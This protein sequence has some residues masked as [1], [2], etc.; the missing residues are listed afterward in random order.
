[1]KKKI[2]IGIPRTFYYS[3]KGII[4]KNFFNK[5]GCNVILSPETNNKIIEEGEK[6]SEK[7]MCKSY[8]IY[9]GHIKELSKKC[10][11]II[12]MINKNYKNTCPNFTMTY[13]NVKEIIP[14]D[15]IIPYKISTNKFNIEILE[16]IKMGTYITPNL[17][18]I[19]KSYLCSVKKQRKYN[20]NKINYQKH[21]QKKDTQKVL[22]MAPFYIMEEKLYLNNIINKLKENNMIPILSNYLNLD[23]SLF[24]KEYFP[25]NIK[26]KYINEMLGA[27][28]YY[29]NEISGVINILNPNCQISSL[30]NSYFNMKVSTTP[31]ISIYTNKINESNDKIQSFILNVKGKKYE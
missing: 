6:I 18:K 2:K 14:P 8:Q 30:I 21:L 13:D 27:Y 22:I 24:F 7:N 12:I 19:I 20:I 16:Y 23:T 9:L 25:C 26:W 29:Q 31:F 15:M 10:D 17:L 4:C 3:R 11:Y 28:Y 1:M 5:L